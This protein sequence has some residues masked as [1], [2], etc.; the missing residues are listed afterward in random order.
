MMMRIKRINYVRCLEQHA[1]YSAQRV[2]INKRSL[3]A[4][5]GVFEGVWSQI[6]LELQSVLAT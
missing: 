3:L 6:H 2:R 1:A 5:A 4:G